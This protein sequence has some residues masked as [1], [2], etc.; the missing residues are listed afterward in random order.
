MNTRRYTARVP[1]ASE[2]DLYLREILAQ[3]DALRRAADAVLDQRA[4]LARVAAAARRRPRIVLTGMGSSFDA[5]YPAVEYLAAHGITAAHANASEVLHFRLGWLTPETTLVLISQSGQSAEVV[6]LAERATSSAER[7]FVLTVTNGLEN[8]LAGHAD[9]SIDMR[10]G[11]EAAPSSMTFAATLTVIAALAHAVSGD[12]TD[13]SCIDVA[14]GAEM[15]AAAVE[16]LLAER[17]P[18]ARIVSHVA[19][20]RRTTVVVGRGAARATAEMGALT[21][22]ECGVVADGFEA[23][24]FR[25]GPFELAGPGLGAVIVATEPMTRPLELG[26]AAELRDSRSAVVV[27]TDDAAAPAAEGTIVLPSADALL[28]PAVSIV[29]IQLAAHRLSIE[30]R[31]EPGSYAFASKVTTRE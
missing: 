19:R 14:T 25:H 2:P 22:Q 12:E 4:A 11:P 17:E 18:I 6:R 5:C 31:R 15:T 3:P 26:L 16:H 7:P 24:A 21:L 30:A 10:T 28:S 8:D 23:G 1:P 9:V 20:N 13:R 27:L 29:P